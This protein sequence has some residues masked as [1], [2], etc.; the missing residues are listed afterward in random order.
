M[1]TVLHCQTATCTACTKLAS[2][3][4]TYN[5]QTHRSLVPYTQSTTGYIRAN[6]ETDTWNRQTDMRKYTDEKKLSSI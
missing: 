3:R 1:V 5:T 6:R 4:T 2:C